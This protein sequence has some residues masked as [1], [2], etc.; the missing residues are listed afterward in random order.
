MNLLGGNEDDKSKEVNI[1]EG[2]SFTLE[3]SESNCYMP[4]ALSMAYP[5][6]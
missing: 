6:L 1:D 3:N 5:R 4:T 2:M